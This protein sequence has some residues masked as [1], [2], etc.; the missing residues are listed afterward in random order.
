MPSL[1]STKR[2]PFKLPFSFNQLP[3]ANVAIDVIG[4]IA[5]VLLTFT[6]HWHIPKSVQGI[7][8]VVMAVLPGL[9]GRVIGRPENRL[10]CALYGI[11][12]SRIIIVVASHRSAL[13]ISEFFVFEFSFVFPVAAANRHRKL[14]VAW[15]VV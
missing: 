5:S 1:Y 2:R 14:S 10:W 11:F 8:V 6:L 7:C 12:R 9:P 15:G 3:T 4:T 13:A